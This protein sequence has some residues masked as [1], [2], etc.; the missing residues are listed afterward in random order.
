[1][2]VACLGSGSDGNATVVRHGSTTLLVDCGFTPADLSRRLS[3]LGLRPGDLDAVLV[4]HEH[5]DHCRG[6]Q[7][8]ARRHRLPVFLSAGTATGLGWAGRRRDPEC[9]DRHILRAGE[10]V[11]LGEIAV[12]PLSAS[13]DAREPLGF[14]FDAN[15]DASL[16]FLTDT[17]HVPADALDGLRGC[18]VLAVETNHCPDLLRKGP[19]PAFLKRRILSSRGHLSNQAGAEL[20]ARVATPALEAV[21]GLHLSKVNNRPELPVQV[22]SACLSGLGLRCPVLPQLGPAPGWL[23]VGMAPAALR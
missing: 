21:L 9:P 18:R 8:F 4:T 2:E 16:G 19:Y 17:G 23:A 3:C 13:H 14:R 10:P 7:S 20:L 6:L 22:M 12:L 15:D 5:G 1:M 11:W